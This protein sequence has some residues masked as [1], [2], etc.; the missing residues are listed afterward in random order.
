[1]AAFTI[2]QHDTRPNLQVPLLD[3]DA[4]I[5]L[6]TA[7]AVKFLMAPHAGGAL[8]VSRACVIV[9]AVAGVVRQIWQA[10]DTATV[11]LYD[12]EFEITWSDGGIETVPSGRYYY[13]IEVVADLG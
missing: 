7:T 8:V 6:S 13:S 3:N 12:A 2:K 9:S 11:G 1:M 5:D 4:A 10:A